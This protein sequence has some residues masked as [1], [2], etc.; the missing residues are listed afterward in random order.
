MEPT[1]GGETKKKKSRERRLFSFPFLCFNFQLNIQMMELV[2]DCSITS[3]TDHWTIMWQIPWCWDL[4]RTHI[5]PRTREL[6]QFPISPKSLF[7]SK[8]RLRNPPKLFGK[9]KVVFSEF[10]FAT[11]L[12]FERFLAP[13][14]RFFEKVN[15]LG[16]LGFSG[17]Y[18]FSKDLDSMR[19]YHYHKRK[20]KKIT[21]YDPTTDDI[22]QNEASV[23]NDEIPYKLNIHVPNLIPSSEF[24][25]QHIQVLH[26][27]TISTIATT[28]ITY[29]NFNAKTDVAEEGTSPVNPI[30]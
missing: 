7:L 1:V 24:R 20:T 9:K 10:F 21:I 11:G 30:L 6:P 17:I 3:F 28:D 27:A 22:L 19:V 25:P 15:G 4:L 5:F 2:T 16:V 18:E 14:S 12:I 29:I 8:N 13:R 26:K 23:Y